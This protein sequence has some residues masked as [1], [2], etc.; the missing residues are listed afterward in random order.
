V[1]AD[2]TKP[3]V[4][5]I[6]GIDT[7]GAISTIARSDVNILAF[8][9]PITHKILLVNTPRDYYV[10]LH[11]TTGTKDKLTHAGTFGIDM[12]IKTM[13]D[14]YSVKIDYYLRV[15]FSSLTS[16]IDSIGGIEINSA[17]AFRMGQYWFDVGLNQLNGAQALAFSRERY[18]FEE[19]DRTRGQNQQRVIEAI[20]AKINN[21]INLLH[22]QQILTSL[23][24][25]VQTNM[26]SDAISNLIN[27]QLNDMHKWETTSISV[28][29]AGSTNV[30]YSM[31]NIPLYVMVPDMASVEFAKTKIGQ[32]Q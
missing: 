31:G 11:G 17:Y 22:Y 15:N 30:T 6:S 9:N 32:W 13:E 1:P 14:L 23:G 7:Y 2:T 25:T 29:G 24:D 18:S 27:M 21:P 20:I 28:T 16:I 4:V 26:S 5:Y 12:S 3:F 10:Q 19:G 8:V